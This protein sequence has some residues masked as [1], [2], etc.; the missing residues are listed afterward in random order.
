MLKVVTLLLMLP[1][2]LT[3]KIRTHLEDAAA[4]AEQ[5]KEN[6]KLKINRTI[7]NQ[8]PVSWTK[9]VY[10]KQIRFNYTGLPKSGSPSLESINWTDIHVRR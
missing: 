1:V 7:D 5:G 9:H 4:T 8:T 2:L 6:T 10:D 3:L